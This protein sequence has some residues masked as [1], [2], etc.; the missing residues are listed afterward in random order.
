M[1]FTCSW[2]VL[3][4]SWHICC[5]TRD[6]SGSRWSITV[7]FTHGFSWKTT[8]LRKIKQ[9]FGIQS[10]LGTH[11]KTFSPFHQCS[12]PTP[13]YSGSTSWHLKEQWHTWESTSGWGRSL[14][15][16]SCAREAFS[17]VLLLC[18]LP[19]SPQSSLTLT[20]LV[21]TTSSPSYFCNSSSTMFF[22]RT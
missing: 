13:R 6:H 2:E 7:I 12:F 4:T 20:G 10:Y 8:K 9:V 1:V 16:S 14:L 3:E 21:Y 5:V 22:I 18:G 11:K 17:D 19:T 15:N